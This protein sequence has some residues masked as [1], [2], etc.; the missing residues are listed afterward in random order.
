[1]FTILL[2]VLGADSK[3]LTGK[4]IWAPYAAPSD[5]LSLLSLLVDRDGSRAT[6]AQQAFQAIVFA[7]KAFATPSTTGLIKASLEYVRQIQSAYANEEDI[8]A[9]LDMA[10]DIF[11]RESLPTG[12]DGLR[13]SNLAF[14]Q[15]CEQAQSRWRC[16]MDRAF[17]HLAVPDI[18]KGVSATQL[19]I[20]TKLIYKDP[21]ARQ[22]IA[23]QVAAGSLGT[24][25]DVRQ[26]ETLLLA[27]CDASACSEEFVDLGPHAEHHFERIAQHAVDHAT[28][29]TDRILAAACIVSIYRAVSHLRES[30]ISCLTQA[31]LRTPVDRITSSMPWIAMA[32]N[33]L[34]GGQRGLLVNH[35]ID[36]G[37][38]WIVRYYAENLQETQDLVTAIDHM[39]DVLPSFSRKCAD[40]SISRFAQGFFQFEVASC[41]T[42]TDR[43]NPTSTWTSTSARLRQRH[44]SAVYAQGK[45]PKVFWCSNANI[46]DQP[47]VVNR[48][49]QNVLQNPRFADFC[50]PTNLRLRDAIVKLLHTL[51][52][53]HPANTCQPSHIEAL[54]RIYRATVSQ[55]DRRLLDVFQ[56]FERSRSLSTGALCDRWSTS[57][58][59][60]TTL[61]ALS[62]LRSL[63]PALVLRTCLLFPRRRSLRRDADIPRTPEAGHLYDPVFLVL[64][65][66]RMMHTGIPETA[67]VWVDLFRTN[68]VSLLICAL[69]AKHVQ[70]RLLALSQLAA[71]RKAMDVSDYVFVET[72]FSTSCRT[73][74]SRKSLLSSTFSAFSKR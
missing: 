29:I 43:S 27:F 44:S 73:R 19:G 39:S 8:L 20:I 47:V 4:L 3:Q 2:S 7:R 28:P 34:E 12:H 36:H 62:G 58:G 59:Y 56:L 26:L 61:T 15:L 60:S 9:E 64:L 54:I 21:C 37:L 53:L 32:V 63:E 69:S 41:G 71:L 68:V 42:C 1:M 23:A 10:V 70:L 52:H 22:S 67:M 13:V 38:K 25:T 18:A 16:R 17:S 11:L 57:S 72:Q 48:Y 6:T 14:P 49:I 24:L 30:I 33:H 5:C 74:I 65:F 31:I 45:V 55:S 35:V 40:T 66:A 46:R 51:F 50:S